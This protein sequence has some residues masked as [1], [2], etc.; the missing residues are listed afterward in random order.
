MFLLAF[1]ICN[2][3]AAGR[4]QVQHK[5]DRAEL[6]AYKRTLNT[7]QDKL[8]QRS[9]EIAQCVDDNEEMANRLAV[10]FDARGN[11]EEL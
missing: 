10:G 4:L 6:F 1:G 3:V 7:C 11:N 2:Q 9:N 5:A 8:T